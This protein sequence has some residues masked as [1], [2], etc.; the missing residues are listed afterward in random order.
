MYFSFLLAVWSLLLLERRHRPLP[1][2][3]PDHKEIPRSRTRSPAQWKP[4]DTLHYV[5]L[6]PIKADTIS[7]QRAVIASG[8]VSCSYDSSCPKRLG[9]LGCLLRRYKATHTDGKGSVGCRCEGVSA[10]EDA[11][12]K[13]SF[14]YGGSCKKKRSMPE[15]ANQKAIVKLL[16]CGRMSKSMELL[17]YLAGSPCCSKIRWSPT[18]LFFSSCWEALKWGVETSSRESQKVSQQLVF[19]FQCLPMMIQ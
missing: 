3:P 13:F 15:S 18:W 16:T 6:V 7:C 2:W 9:V 5:T 12:L 14:H 4:S 11:C 1:L 19:R 10:K 8:K 17:S